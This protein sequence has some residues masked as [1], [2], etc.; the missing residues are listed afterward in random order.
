VCLPNY[1][2]CPSDRIRITPSSATCPIP[3][4]S[5]YLFTREED[6]PRARAVWESTAQTNFKKSLWEAR[7]KAVKIAG[8]Q[9]P[10]AWMDYG[11]ET[12]ERTMADRYVEGT[13]QP[14]LH[15]KV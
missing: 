13:P 7:D 2:T 5:R 14:D 11:L 8:S 10:M 6:L 12:Y 15:P 9:D 3:F 4:T 1:V